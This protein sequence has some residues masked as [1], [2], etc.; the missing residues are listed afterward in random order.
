VKTRLKNIKPLARSYLF[1]KT[2]ISKICKTCIRCRISHN[3]VVIKSGGKK[4]E[5]IITLTSYGQRVESTAPYAIYSLFNQTILPDR[6]VLWLKEATPVPPLLKA[7]E[8]NGLEI[9]FC[10]D[11]YSYKKLVPSLLKF[12]DDILITADDDAYYHRQWL[13]QLKTAYTSRPEAIHCHRAREINF[14]D[15]KLLPYIDWRINVDNNNGR[16][17]LP[18]GAGGILYPPHSLDPKV[19]DKDIFM[20]LAPKADDIWFWAMAKL[21]G[22]PHSVVNKGYELQRINID[23][24]ES[25]NGLMAANLDGGNDAQLEAVLKAYPEILSLI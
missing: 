11:L 24:A 1:I 10:E 21:K 14:Q 8:K 23:P 6:I 13:N 9:M 5:Y 17:L 12:P 3:S 15:G 20:K 22:T 19:T 16:R 4:P 2:F 18:T 25:A 7:F